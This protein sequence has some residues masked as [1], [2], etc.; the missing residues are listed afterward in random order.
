M[1][2]GA[3]MTIPSGLSIVNDLFRDP[4]ERA[5]AVGL[6]SGTIGLGIAVGPVAGGL[7]LSR[8]WWGSVFLVNV[9]GCRRRIVGTLLLVPESRSPPRTDLTRLG[10]GA[11]DRRAWGWSCGRSSRDRTSGGSRRRS[12]PPARPGWR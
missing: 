7:L 10:V 9:A 8:F 2:A 5:R 12:W 4:A 11:L 6:W 1:G 3:A